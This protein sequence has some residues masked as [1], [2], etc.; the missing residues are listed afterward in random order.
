MPHRCAFS[1]Q[2]TIPE[3]PSFASA[4]LRVAAQIDA[5]S[6]AAIIICAQLWGISC[7]YVTLQEMPHTCVRS[8]LR[9]QDPAP[10]PLGQ[11]ATLSKRPLFAS[12]ILRAAAL[13]ADRHR[14]E[15]SHLNVRA[16]MEHF[17]RLPSFANDSH[18][19]P[20]FCPNWE[21]LPR[22]R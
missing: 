9:S 16:P 1:L 8:F 3:R 13:R 12:A 4:I 17:L 10:P 2:A 18:R 22:P 5:A 11:H 14:L 19:C 21:T 15:S 20:L 7:I 6:K